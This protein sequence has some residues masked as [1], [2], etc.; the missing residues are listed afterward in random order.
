MNEDIDEHEWLAQER[1]MSG[2][3]QSPG[4]AEGNAR[5]RSYRLIAH[6]LR[7]PPPDNLPPHFAQRM[8]RIAAA[9]DAPF[10]SVLISVLVAALVICAIITV[11]RFGSQWA[12]D[13][14]TSGW[15]LAFAGC[16]GASWLTEAWQRRAR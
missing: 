5:A 1:A 16:L 13:A 15:L 4:F 7:Q 12:F 9:D 2:E 3:L 10:E 11:A 6:A 14:R 8:S